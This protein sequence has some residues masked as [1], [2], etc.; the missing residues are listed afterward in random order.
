V[1]EKAFAT[2]RTQQIGDLWDLRLHSIRKVFRRSNLNAIFLSYSKI[3]RI[4]LFFILAEAALS[5]V[6]M[7]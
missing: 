1:R 7:A 4:P 3:S 2:V 6:L 5:I